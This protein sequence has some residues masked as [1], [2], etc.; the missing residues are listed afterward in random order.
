MP[1]AEISEQ[2]KIELAAQL[3]RAGRTI[4][5]K[6]TGTSMLPSVWPSDTLLIEGCDP[7]VVS[8][9]EILFVVRDGRISIH[10]LSHRPN[11]ANQRWITRGD[12]NPQDDPAVDS[13]QILGRVCQIYRYNRLFTPRCKSS[14]SARALSWLFCRSDVVRGIAMRV[15]SIRQNRHSKQASV[16]D[17]G[18]LRTNHQNP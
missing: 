15:H 6:A 4:R 1:T 9:G 13:E 7:A 17:F 8:V 3:L 10:R 14:M 16:R 2:N 11:A 5:V 12:C 18:E